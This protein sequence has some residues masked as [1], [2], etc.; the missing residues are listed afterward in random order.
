MPILSTILLTKR[1]T[2]YEIVH[3]YERITIVLLFRDYR[4]QRFKR[5]YNLTLNKN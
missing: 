1:Y 4:A 3:K 2:T 5:T